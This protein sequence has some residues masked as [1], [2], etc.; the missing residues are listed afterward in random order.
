MPLSTLRAMSSILLIIVHPSLELL[1][2]VESISS[3]VLVGCA[4]K[5]I[6]TEHNEDNLKGGEWPQRE[7]EK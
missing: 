4:T 6:V 7:E 5:A 3:S 1:N 2:T